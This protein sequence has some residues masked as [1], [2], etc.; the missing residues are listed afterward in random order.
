MHLIY[1]RYFNNK[2]TIG[3]LKSA[4]HFNQVQF[5]NQMNSNEKNAFSHAE[6][7]ASMK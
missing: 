5:L 1:Y 7:S 3:V 6:I 4:K 2:K